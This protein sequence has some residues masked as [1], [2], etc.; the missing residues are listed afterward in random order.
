MKEV[1]DNREEIKRLRIVEEYIKSELIPN[2]KQ[3]ETLLEEYN[4]LIENI[5]DKINRLSSVL[6]I[7][8]DTQ[9]FKQ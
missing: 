2:C 7:Q 3:N 5:E 1:Y 6:D 8:E 9:T 4:R